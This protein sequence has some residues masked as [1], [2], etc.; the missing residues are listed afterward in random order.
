MKNE[1][2]GNK[3]LESIIKASINNVTRFL[4][5]HFLWLWTK[6]L[7]TGF[8]SCA[9]RFQLL[10]PGKNKQPPPTTTK[11]R[12]Q[13]ATR[14]CK[15]SARILASGQAQIDWQ[16]GLRPVKE[17]R[18]RQNMNLSKTAISSWCYKQSFSWAGTGEPE[19]PLW[20]R[21]SAQP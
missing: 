18:I 3:I 12:F 1:V 8:S 15:R 17:K 5:W 2:T 9:V 14:S 16:V 13:P 11:K 4:V 7:N 6:Y 19:L 20:E 10:L 21:G